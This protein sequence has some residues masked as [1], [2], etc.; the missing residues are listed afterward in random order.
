MI[1]LHFCPI[2]IVGIWFFTLSIF[3]IFFKVF[4]K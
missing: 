4:T 1:F 2:Q 3:L